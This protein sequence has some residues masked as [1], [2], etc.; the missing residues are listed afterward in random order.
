MAGKVG[1]GL[2]C[3]VTSRVKG[4]PFEVLL[5]AS[6]KVSGVVLADQLKSLGWEARQAKRIEGAHPEVVAEVLA[7][8]MALLE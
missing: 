2:F 4:Y 3:P 8:I 1:R 5:P 6:G 7:K